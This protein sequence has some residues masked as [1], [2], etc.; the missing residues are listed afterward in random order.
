MSENGVEFQS[1]LDGT[2]HVFTAENVID[3]QRTIGSDIAMVLDECPPALS[4][5]DYHRD[6]MERS[7]R[8]ARR[9]KEHHDRT[10]FPYGHRQALFGI[11]QGGTHTDLRRASAEALMAIGFDGYAIGGLAV[12]EPTEVMYEVVE[13]IA[14]VLPAGQPR[15]LMGVGTPQ[16]LL[17]CVARG[18]DMFDCVMPTRNARNGSVFTWRGKVNL[19]NALHREDESPIDQDCGCETCRDYSRGYIRHLF[20]V[21]EITGLTL[22]T[23][24]NVSFYLRLMEKAREAIRAGEYHAWMRE[25]L[26]RMQTSPARSGPI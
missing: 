7:M 20:N 4:S 25:T 22:A 5:Y 21:D 23:I 17:E 3:T 15:Y 24:H 10:P 16:N 12:G 14:P 11:V 9:A 19:R 8:W 6:S 1:H 2:R 13:R 18:I 26:E